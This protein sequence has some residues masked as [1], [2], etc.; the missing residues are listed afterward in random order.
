MQDSP[1]LDP[2]M[3]AVYER[4]AAPF[5]FAA[6]ASDLV[7]IIGL[8]EGAVVLDVGTGTG[9][10]AA[11]AIAAV[12][13]SGI[14]IGTDSAF[15][16]VRVA[17][18]ATHLVVAQVPGLPFSDDTFDAVVAGFVVSHFESYLDGLR[19]M[20]RV[21]RTGG[22][23]GMSAWGSA[24][25]PAASLW[26]D[27]AAQFAPRERLTEAF[28]K[29]IPWDTWF[30]RIDNVGEALW[31]AGLSSV[32]TE[33]RFYTVRMPTPAY[34]LSREASIQGLILRRQL[35]SAQWDHFKITAAEAFEKKF[36]DSVEYDRDAHFGVG[37]KR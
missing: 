14:V 32:T 4:V 35:T 13:I 34:L 16:M 37:T 21:C 19:E 36:G 2:A 24:P 11:A 27:L 22:H 12:G 3:V 18:N 33:T 26:S 7:K 5:Q 20:L 1:Y 9:V 31:S 10:V 29:Q 28:L 6:P 25:N 23:I 17:R 8:S 30:S 15:E